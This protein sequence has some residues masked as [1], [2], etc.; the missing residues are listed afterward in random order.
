MSYLSFVN[1]MFACIFAWMMGYKFLNEAQM[2][3]LRIA[4]SIHLV[5]VALTVIIFMWIA[6]HVRNL[7][8]EEDEQMKAFFVNKLDYQVRGTLRG[9]CSS[10]GRSSGTRARSPSWWSRS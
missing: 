10:A 3:G 6:L 1:W 2:K 7:S 4:L 5:G 9:S 8:A